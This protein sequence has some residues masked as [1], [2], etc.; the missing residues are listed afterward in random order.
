[1]NAWYGTFQLVLHLD[2]RG[3]TSYINTYS[4]CCT[5]TGCEY[6]ALVKSSKVRAYISSVLGRCGHPFVSNKWPES[7]Q[8]W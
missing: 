1:M 2:V 5:Y 6:I 8:L 4:E 3:D 7:D